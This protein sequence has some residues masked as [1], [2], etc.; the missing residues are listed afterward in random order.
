MF[1]R[2]K[3]TIK[4][5]KIGVPN[6]HVMRLAQILKGPNTV[7]NTFQS[8]LIIL[9][10]QG[11]SRL[12]SMSVGSRECGVFQSESSLH[13]YAISH[14]VKKKKLDHNLIRNWQVCFSN[15]REF[16]ES[17]LR[18]FQNRSNSNPEIILI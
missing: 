5:L 18:L 14:Q 13:K 9:S 1:L 2:S 3:Y 6:G 16:R 10:L 15:S 17:L 4:K 11:Y 8:G 7:M 12:E